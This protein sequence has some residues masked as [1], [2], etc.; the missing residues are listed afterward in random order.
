MDADESKRSMITGKGI[1]VPGD[2][3]DTDRIIPARYLKF[4]TFDSLGRHVFQDERYDENGN[5]KDH[6]FNEDRFKGAEILLVNKNFGCGSSREHAPQSIMRAG[7]RGIVG[8]SFGEIF[9]GNC[10]ALGIPTVCLKREE[11][12]FLMSTVS[13]KPDTT[14]ELNLDNGTV[15]AAG[16]SYSLRAKDPDCIRST[17]HLN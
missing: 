12:D 15:S 11:L 2:D 14:I 8:E 13:K 4:V 1:P 9:A 10:T 17:G 16:T 6:P 3:I 5:E 7:I